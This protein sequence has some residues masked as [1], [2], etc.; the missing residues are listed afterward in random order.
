M[1]VPVKRVV[2]QTRFGSYLSTRKSYAE[3]IDT[4]SH[5]VSEDS[6][7]ACQGMYKST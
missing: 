7:H 1:W 5:Q 3:D 6:E 2:N 4:S